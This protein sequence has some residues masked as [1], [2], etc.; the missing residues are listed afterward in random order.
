MFVAGPGKVA[1]SPKSKAFPGEAGTR[2]P[3]GLEQFRQKRAA[4]LPS[5]LRV[6]NA[7]TKE[8]SDSV[9]PRKAETP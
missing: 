9:I 7:Q 2:P 8:W 6:N 4:V 1:R 3:E 5:E